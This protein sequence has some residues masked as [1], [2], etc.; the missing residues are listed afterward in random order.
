[1]LLILQ[2][3]PLI[4]LGGIGLTL[5][6]TIFFNYSPLLMKNAL[7]R[8]EE[9]KSSN[10]W[11]SIKTMLT[12]RRWL[13]GLIVNVVGGIFYILALEIAGITL[14]QPLLNFGFIVLVLAAK[15]LLGE[16]LDKGAKVAIGL[17]ITMPVF[18]T[19]SA[20]SEP[21]AISDYGMIILFSLVCLAIIVGLGVISQK[22]AIL[23]A[24]TTGVSLGISALYMQWFT[25]L[26]FD[27]TKST[28]NVFTALGAAFVPLLL[29]MVGNIIA[30]I[31]FMQIGL[32]KNPA[33]RFNPI[34]GTVN[35]IVSIIGGM[36]IF[37]QE[38]GNWAFYIIGIGL[39]VAG[40]LL[41]S[42]YQ[43]GENLLTNGKSRDTRGISLN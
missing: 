39:G 18:M 37:G 13:L 38:I 43:V 35:M 10:L 1:M 25:T 27:V 14:V 41:L 9:I 31:V 3:D 4:Y 32:Q 34:N 16:E 8:M 36:L 33:S 7:N 42:R 22:V 29:T 15:R 24:L 28:G 26:F 40:I 12:N 19:L 17:L 11:K 23:W 5:L 6:A 20:V 30:N 2:T 21:R